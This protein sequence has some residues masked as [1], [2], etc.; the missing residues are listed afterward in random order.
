MKEQRVWQAKLAA[1]IHD[2]ASKALILMRGMAHEKGSVRELRRAIFGDDENLSVLEELDSVVKEADH[3]A[4][5]ADRPFLPMSIRGKV[6]FTKEPALIHPLTGQYFQVEQ[7]VSDRE[8]ASP[9]AIEALNFD[10]FNNFIVNDGSGGIDWRCTFLAFW[11]FGKVPPAPD[12]GVLWEQLPADTRSPDHSIWEH[13]GLASAFAGALEAGSD[14]GAALLLVSFGPVQGFIAQARSVSDL[15]AG[16]HLLSTLSWQG[17]KVICDRYGP[18]AVLFPSLHGVPLV[19]VWLRNEACLKEVWPEG[20]S[21][22]KGG[23][24]RNPLFAAALPNRFLALIP[25]GD[26]E[27]LAG[28]IEQ[29]TRRW[30]RNRMDEVLDEIEL[31][32]NEVAK[33]QVE[34][35][36]AGFP[37]V[38]WAIVPWRLAQGK[39][40]ELDDTPLVEAL[41]QLGSNGKYLDGKAAALVKKEIELDGA[42]FFT[43]NPGVVYPG[44]YELSERLH[45]AAKMARPFGGE[46]DQGYRCSV[47][48]EREW[49][50][51]DETTLDQTPGQRGETIWNRVRE[52]KGFS[53]IKK[54][55]HLCA[56]CSLKRFWPRIFTKWA[57]KQ[58]STEHGIN[59]YVISTHTM[60]LASSLWRYSSTVSEENNGKRDAKKLL[61]ERMEQLDI[62]D[63]DG[64]ALPFKLYRILR[65]NEEE[66]SFFKRLPALLDRMSDLEDDEVS[67]IDA[68][69]ERRE[70]ESHIKKLLGKKPEAYYAMVLMDGDRMGKWLAAAGDVPELGSRFHKNILEELQRESALQDYIKT[71]RPPSPAWH[72]AIS[73]GLNAFAIEM[74]RVVVE[75]IF[76][77]KLIYAGGDDLLAMVAVHDLPGLMLAL[78]CAY[79]G[80]MPQDS[81]DKDASDHFRQWEW[82]TGNAMPQSVQLRLSGGYALLERGTNRRLLRLM[83]EKATASIGAVVA[84]H[85][86]PLSRVLTELRNAEKAAK[87]QG[88]RDAFALT[89]MKRSGGYSRI[90]GNWRL[91]EGLREGD[92]GLLLRLRDLLAHPYLSRRAAYILSEVVK[93]IPP[94]EDAMTK[95]IWRQF[96]RQGL[97]KKAKGD[98]QL[99][100]EAKALASGL[101]ARAC[102]AKDS[103]TAKQIE[104]LKRAGWQPAGAWL[105]DM[106]ITAEFLARAGRAPE[107]S[108]AQGGAA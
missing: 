102:K 64:A 30:I 94:L 35:Q 1:Y 3:W 50:T 52:K 26:A 56:L 82:L 48:G 29:Q 105:R 91:E 80:H 69:A 19:D 10:H 11:R 46:G 8:D 72:Q 70:V 28:E 75:E 67:G 71:K 34:R 36:L 107:E 100:T 39:E 37:E 78:R 103:L 97:S 5:A 60:A 42:P 76:M 88:G 43:P 58:G 74:A 32:E 53:F 33:E 85:K 63:K 65:G 84:H 17:M 40:G 77:G 90:V 7:L 4:S 96:L 6:V 98:L 55:E 21:Y 12:L 95:V 61:E 22:P 92:M 2:P 87:N 89:L 106:F 99:L 15:W 31:S 101:S 23:S 49:L 18:D 83:G 44:L 25:A 62:K 16:S 54:G 108:K 9:H 14:K 81:D 73:A 27:Y 38:N 13:L 57:E 68:Q 45:A 86:T 41:N 79:S 20:A 93:D 24:D 51:D 104:S 59:R 47:C 66:L